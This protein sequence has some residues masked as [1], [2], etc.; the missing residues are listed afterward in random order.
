MVGYIRILVQAMNV[1]HCIKCDE[2]KPLID[3]HN[4]KNSK[5]GKTVY[6]KSCR[7]AYGRRYREK[8]KGDAELY[9]RQIRNRQNYLRRNNDPRSKSFTISLK[10][11]RSLFNNT[12]KCHYCKLPVSDF[13]KIEDSHIPRTNRLSFDCVVIVVI[14]LKTTSSHMRT[15]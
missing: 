8:H 13:N 3:F 14:T 7:L 6:C 9:Y 15:L 11:F 1:K 4:N 2:T 12:D 10:E 5:D